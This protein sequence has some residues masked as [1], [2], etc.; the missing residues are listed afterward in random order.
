MDPRAVLRV[1]ADLSAA[2]T[3]VDRPER[4]TDVIEDPHLITPVGHAVEKLYDGGKV[5][6]WSLQGYRRP[7]QTGRMLN[8]VYLDLSKTDAFGAPSR[9]VLGQTGAHDVIEWPNNVAQV[10]AADAVHSGE[11]RMRVGWVWF[12]G[13]IS[14]DGEGIRFCFPAISV[15]VERVDGFFS[16]TN[17]YTLAAVSDAGATD[18]IADP[19]LRERLLAGRDFGSGSLGPAHY[20]YDARMVRRLDRMNGWIDDVAKAV[21]IP[22]HRRR[23][24]QDGLPTDFR[25]DDGITMIVGNYLYID[26]PG[27][28]HTTAAR[29]LELAEL[30]SME[31]TAFAKIYSDE[32]TDDR[33]KRLA[34]ELRPMSAR[35][36]QVTSNAL[37]QEVSV[38]SGPP[39]TGKS[40]LVTVAALD[41]ISRRKSVL[42]A[43]SSH[44]AVDVLVQHFIDTPG[45]TPVVFGGTARS[46]DLADQLAEHGSEAK[47]DA[48][49]TDIE[50][51]AMAEH[52][53]LIEDIRRSLLAE[54][55]TS[56]LRNDPDELPRVNEA[57]GR[58]GDLDE[59]ES[60]IEAGKRGGPLGWNARRRSSKELERRLGPGDPARMLDAV[61]VQS[62][63]R[64]Q[65]VEDGLTLDERLDAL[66]ALES[67]AADQ[68]GQLITQAWLGSL[69]QHERTTLREVATA[70]SSSRVDRRESLR[71]MNPDRLVRS[72][73]LWVGSVE[74]IDEVLPPVAAMFDLVI[75]DEAA[76]IDQMDAA[77]AL[78]RGRDA[79][80]VGD[81][82]QLDHALFL[83]DEVIDEV[84]EIYNV[85][86]ARV[87]PRRDSI[88]DAAASVAPTHVLTEHFRSAPHLIE[89]SA[90]RVYENSLNVV[91][92]H[93][94]NEAADHIDVRLVEGNRNTQK[95]NVAEVAECL[96]VAREMIEAGHTSIGFISPFRAQADAIEEAV[97]AGF[98][99]EEIDELGLRVGTVHSFQ[100][101]ERDVMIASWGVGPEEDQKAWN[102]VNQ[103]PLFNVMVTR[104]REEMVV[105]TSV[106]QPPGLA[107]E[108]VR[109]SEPLT[110]L[111]TDVPSTD[112][113][114]RAVESAFREAEL[115][116]R[117][118]Y[119]VGGHL[120]DLVVGSGADAMAIDCVPHEDGPEAHIDRALQLRRMGWKTADCYE[121]KWH[122]QVAQFVSTQLKI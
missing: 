4:L 56:R 96:R 70:M 24:I 25:S 108:Y 75:L 46:Q 32:S 102:F 37:A 94:A 55:V 58:A 93:P 69:R 109:W 112:P 119:R 99:L 9:F 79:V 49:R 11:R 20:G 33:P 42:V 68:R 5:S 104:A 88:L 50:T 113:W 76:Q 40:H 53:R 118:G 44:H 100:G 61:R 66:M 92:R 22:I 101:D 62:A 90:R 18:L 110:D 64:T 115:P 48:D 28:Y 17:G 23:L 35:Q 116:V 16:G 98:Q 15:P 65:L 34:Q 81:P 122:D 63:A 97:L 85:D 19:A 47:S 27:Q 41:A 39:G 1:F 7:P 2:G 84:T 43:A 80:V 121:S 73:P 30:H 67:V 52:D 45:P 72:A 54:A 13:T 57:L 91:T 89:F 26:Q 8:N 87:N 105:V 74:D 120:I 103:K 31:A 51:P 36:R 3:G 14:V 21:G 117:S 10:L 111:V 59:L 38:L 60:L 12:A 29:L 95:V 107:G 71:Q 6:E 86:S 106:E 78:V 82:Y 114:V 77:I 83:S